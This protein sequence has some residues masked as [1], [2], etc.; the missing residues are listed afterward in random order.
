MSQK[1]ITLYTPHSIGTEEDVLATKSRIFESFEQDGSAKEAMQVMYTF[2]LGSGFK[3]EVISPHTQTYWAW[4]VRIC[5]ENI[6]LVRDDSMFIG[7]VGHTASYALGQGYD[8]LDRY[9]AYFM[10]RATEFPALNSVHVKVGQ[11]L[12]ETS[13][14]VSLI[15]K[16]S[17]LV[18]E[19]VDMSQ[20][21]NELSTLESSDFLAKLETQIFD[22]MPAAL[23]EGESSSVQRAES[24]RLLL[25][26]YYLCTVVKDVEP[27]VREYF[28][29]TLDQPTEHI[30]VDPK[31]YTIGYFNELL[32]ERGER[33]I[34]GDLL[35]YDF[36]VFEYIKKIANDQHKNNNGP[37]TVTQILKDLAIVRNESRICDV[38]FYNES[39]GTFEWDEKLLKEL[40]LVP[41]DFDM[42]T[43]K[44]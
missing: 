21:I 37:S 20:R 19:V 3:K 34:G 14:P 32:Q 23:V 22:G 16:T 28:F 12:Q 9:L 25:G 15:S 44:M 41:P 11:A 27:S 2:F 35:F 38:Y 10:S 30:E 24:I 26:L 1:N 8:V 5:W 13:S 33:P 6:D 42:S 36:D 17:F 4:F 31:A 40:K 7:I 18:R 43:I 39:T 29:D